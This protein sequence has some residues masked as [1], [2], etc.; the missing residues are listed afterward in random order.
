MIGPTYLRARDPLGFLA[1]E[2]TARDAA[3]AAHLSARGRAAPDPRS[4]ARRRCSPATRSRGRKGEGIEFADIR[5]WAPGDPLKRVNWRASARRGELWVNESHPERN[6][7]V[8]LFVDSFAEA[9]L[10][11]EGTLDLAVRATAALADAYVR[12]RDRVGLIGFGGILR[13]LA[14][15]TGIVQLYRIIDALLDTQIVLSYYWKEIDVIPRRTLP[16]SALVIALSP[17]LDPRSVGALLDL[18]AR[19]FDLAV[20]DVSPVP[21][22]RT[23]GDAASTRIALRHLDAATRRASS[24]SAARGRRR[25]RVGRRR[26]R[27]RPSSRRCG[28]SGVTPGT[29]AS[30]HRRRRARGA[31]RDERVRRCERRTLRRV[32]LGAAALAFALLALGARAALAVA[33]S[34]GRSCRRRAATWSAREGNDVVDGW[35]AVDRRAAARSPPSSRPGRSSTTRASA[36]ERRCSSA[37]GPDAGVARA[38]R[39]ARQLHAARRGGGLGVGG[40]GDRGRR[41]RRGGQRASS[42]CSGS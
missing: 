17:L 35:A 10:G 16:P 41:R 12:R 8:I 4:R 5:P 6:T 13:W 34:R 39:A 27:C 25:R 23:A 28:N 3:A 15:G 19:G 21:F 14:P 22:T 1:W 29:R 7:D 26:S 31:R 36:A 9:R 33:R 11:D 18:R 42:S 2:A 30:D 37:R 20:I 32:A 40:R 38:R 24:P